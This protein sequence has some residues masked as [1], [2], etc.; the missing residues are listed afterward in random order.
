ML[1]PILLLSAAGF[2]ILTTEF[3]I[4][5]L[6]PSLARDLDVTVSQAGLLVSLFAFT[7]AATGPL[8]TALMANIERKRLFISVLV[9]FGLS[10][11]LAAA[12]PNICHGGGPLRARPGVAGVLVA[13][14]RHGGGTCRAGPRRTRHLDGG[15][16]HRRRDRVRHSHR[17][18]DFRCVWLARGLRRALGGGI[19]Q[20]AVAAAG[21]SQH[22]H[23]RRERR[24]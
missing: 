17:R 20:G 23:P 21:L 4:V 9:L 11:A 22:P 2:T 10:N 5:G 1:L 19:R 12:A 15:V 18:A 6:L 16:R 13:G 14:Q 8:L 7:V 3:L 24:W